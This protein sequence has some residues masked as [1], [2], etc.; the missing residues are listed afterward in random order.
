MRSL[1]LVFLSLI[2]TSCMSTPKKAVTMTPPKATMTVAPS[3]TDFEPFLRLFQAE[4]L[5][6]DIEIVY[7]YKFRVL[8]AKNLNARHSAIGLCSYDVVNIIYIDADYWARATHWEQELLLFHEL[9]HCV[10]GIRF[11]DNSRNQA[12]FPLSIMSTYIIP[13]VYYARHRAY[14]LDQLFATHLMIQLFLR[15]GASKNME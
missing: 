6:R 8:M 3:D 14:Y 7:P 11:H 1:I 15:T 9:G 5:I 4:A 2:L 13:E 10:L 12:G